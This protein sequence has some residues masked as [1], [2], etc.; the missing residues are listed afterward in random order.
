MQ[1]SVGACIRSVPHFV[2]LSFRLLL[3]LLISFSVAELWAASAI[4]TEKPPVF[5]LKSPSLAPQLKEAK[6]LTALDGVNGYLSEALV[7]SAGWQRLATSSESDLD[8]VEISFQLI[9]IE[10]SYKAK[11]GVSHQSSRAEGLLHTVYFSGRNMRDISCQ[12]NSAVNSR[13]TEREA[14]TS[15]IRQ[16]ITTC[17]KNLLNDRVTEISVT[18]DLSPA[19]WRISY[20]KSDGSVIGDVLTYQTNGLETS[21]FKVVSVDSASSII[22]AVSHG[23]ALK[24]GDKLELFKSKWQQ[25]S[26]FGFTRFAVGGVTVSDRISGSY[27]GGWLSGLA[28]DVA[29]ELDND[30]AFALINRT[31][32]HKSET[33]FSYSDLGKSGWGLLTVEEKKQY[34]DVDA[35]IYIAIEDEGWEAP[36][37]N[38]ITLLGDWYPS[39]RE[40]GK[41]ITARIIGLNPQSGSLLINDKVHLTMPADAAESETFSKQQYTDLIV[42]GFALAMRP[43]QIIA[44]SQANAML[45]HREGVVH[46]GQVFDVVSGAT[47]SVDSTSG[48][49]LEGLR[50]T[51]LGRVTITGFN[52][53]GWAELEVNEGRVCDQCNAILK[54]S[55]NSPATAQ[56]TAD[57]ASGRKISPR[58][59]GLTGEA[60]S[61]PSDARLIVAPLR[62]GHAFDGSSDLQSD[63]EASFETQM[64]NELSNSMT[65]IVAGRNAEDV[66]ATMLYEQLASGKKL[67]LPKSLRS[68]TDYI[69]FIQLDEIKTAVSGG[70]K[71]TL[72]GIVSKKIYTTQVDARLHLLSSATSD[73]VLSERIKRT[74]ASDQEE[75]GMTTTVAEVWSIVSQDVL[76]RIDLYL[77]PLAI[78]RFSDDV[79]ILTHGKNIGLK[80]GG[81]VRVYTEAGVPLDK[82]EILDF[83]STGEAIF[84][85]A[86]IRNL[87]LGQPVQVVSPSKELNTP[88][89]RKVKKLNW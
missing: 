41:K 10:L 2:R 86:G 1:S 50:E 23:T 24:P 61:T 13:H 3:L 60:V 58:G 28:L 66:A 30:P 59:A 32:E 76:A 47:L 33:E 87:K 56:I 40:Q 73:V 21:W 45:N 49:Q 22:R 85:I 62:F 57:T 51:L 17:V 54:A 20:K 15:L 46:V 19:E 37:E 64:V 18:H 27:A 43:P 69:A 84:S 77:K 82:A 26:G 36:E 52:A 63:L 74:L 79:A 65:F 55:N 12:I 38:F 4:D 88:K 75:R 5:T 25:N 83:T 34:R 42:S 11:T 72:T 8:G 9:D 6:N 53:S 39:A 31:I 78:K 81:V 48:E 35:L 67:T 80:E 44:D 16:L 29:L 14:K 7:Q 71:N 68:K 70:L 89:P